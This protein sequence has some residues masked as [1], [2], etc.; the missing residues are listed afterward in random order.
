MELRSDSLDFE[1]RSGFGPQTND[2]EF[3]FPR[4]V[5]SATAGIAGYALV[6][7]DHDDHEV[8]LM[9]VRLETSIN[10]NVVVVKGILG[11]RDWSG[12]WD[13]KYGG[14]IDFV[15]LAELEDPTATPPRTDMVVTGAEFNQAVQ[16]FRSN[17]YLDGDNV[18]PDN[19]IPLTSHKS[20]GV[21]VFIDYDA[22]SGLAP[23]ATLDGKLEVRTP[24][25]RFE[26]AAI[27]GGVVV[28]RRDS[29]INQGNPDHTLNFTIPSAWCVGEIEIS[30]ECFEGGQPNQRAA[31]F[32]R[33]LQFH[34]VAALN[35]YTVGVHYTGQGRDDPAPPQNDIVDDLVIMEE[36]FPHGTINVTGYSV[37][38]FGDD[39]AGD[40][41][42]GCGS[43]W[44]SL[45][46]DLDDMKGESNDI[47]VAELPTG[48][49]G[50]GVGG[51]GS[52][53]NGVCVVFTADP[54][55]LA[56]EVGHALGRKHT[57]CPS[58]SPPPTNADENYP[59][60]GSFLR[61]SIGVYGFRPDTGEVFDP[62]TTGDL[63]SYNPVKWIG[64]Y[65]YNA[66]KGG[67]GGDLTSYGGSEPNLQQNAVTQVLHLGL[68]I[69]RFDLV[70][71]RPSFHFDT[72][73]TGG[74]EPGDYFIEILD[75]WGKVRSRSTFA[76]SSQGCDKCSTGI[77][78]LSVR[79]RLVMPS[80]ARFLNV[81][82]EQRKV[83][84]EVIP[85][86]PHIEVLSQG[87]E[88]EGVH[89]TWAAFDGR[90]KKKL[91]CAWYL[92]HWFDT[93]SKTWRGLA[94]RRQE[95]GI[96]IPFRHF[97]RLKSVSI[98]IYATTGIATGMVELTVT[99]SKLPNKRLTDL[100]HH[101]SERT[102][103]AFLDTS[104]VKGRASISPKT[105]LKL[106]AFDDLGRSTALMSQNV[107]WYG[108]D[109][110]YLGRGVCA[111]IDKKLYLDGGVHLIVDDGD[112]LFPIKI[113]A[114]KKPPR[115]ILGEPAE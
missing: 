4:A 8:G 13:D 80:D 108:P 33:T 109:S 70:T 36:M 15:V 24:T 85:P 72:I 74:S 28:P 103:T 34:D 111:A 21:R 112:S 12:N 106:H 60:Y 19:S 41:G 69:A 79:T 92:V 35:I 101:I 90:D 3:V 25:A 67:G 52:R 7:D 96:I 38:E 82:H 98:R 30:I 62:A 57:P 29:Q 68:D 48:P 5:L 1:A 87:Y 110:K 61:E 114:S 2:R 75:Q 37:L 107:S 95:P 77:F 93:R 78:P 65:T 31:A 83:Y 9:Q 58:C 113:S 89:L 64:P 115:L 42:N 104:V 23:I 51:C 39:L 100:H 66:L 44:S 46:D 56:H 53:S 32:V 45:L 97:G 22:T 54:V 99:A 102:N 6:F 91:F 11:I 14:R 59:Q 50:G 73:Y 76:G 18:R 86:A 20:T 26:V 71:R 17:R 47:F 84:E 10:N 94:P 55:S 43:G 88:K 105:V 49:N 40:L 27:N 81:W 63:M 16:Y